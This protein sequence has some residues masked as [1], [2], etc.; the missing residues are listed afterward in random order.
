M[1]NTR[2]SLPAATFRTTAWASG[3][4][5]TLTSGRGL[6]PDDLVP[7]LLLPGGHL[8]HPDVLR[9]EVLLEAPVAVLAADPG[10]LVTAERRGGRDQVVVVHPHRAGA[11]A[12][13]H[14]EGPRDVPRP[15]GA[16]QA[17]DGVVRH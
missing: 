14:L 5:R 15:H 12:L 11:V 2:S 3:V 17:V 6:Q 4:A 1:T 13:G 7:E 10:L 9:L 8:V 16:A